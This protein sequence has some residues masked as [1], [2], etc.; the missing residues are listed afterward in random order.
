MAR[1]WFVQ[2]AQVL[3]RGFYK[4]GVI[5]LSCWQFGQ[6]KPLLLLHGLMVDNRSF[7]PLQP[8][9]GTVAHLIAP[10]LRGHGRSQHLSPSNTVAQHVI[11]IIHLLDAL[12]L[13]TISVMG[14]SLGGAIAQQ[15]AFKC[16]DRVE[17]LMLVC[18]FACNTLSARERFE[19]A[20]MPAM[21]RIL[22][23]ARVAEMVTRNARELT[24]TKAAH[25]QNMI[26]SVSKAH[27][28]AS[29][30]AMKQFDSRPW[31]KHIQSPTLVVGGSADSAVPPVHAHMLKRQIPEAR[32][33]IINGA[34]HTLL[35]THTDSLA[36]LMR[37]F[38]A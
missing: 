23:M 2:K 37:E 18:T 38:L 4:G 5:M 25:L 9:L 17:R 7:E 20:L 32:L 21:I 16:P 13:Q 14:Y 15:L 22:G 31:L 33:Q 11:D 35:W 6:G 10:D 36:R 12:G 27:A 3:T 28:L 8:Y 19:A 24:P 30:H 34:S 29:L 1:R 26:S